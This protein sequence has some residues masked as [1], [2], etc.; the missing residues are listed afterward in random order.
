V[1]AGVD[2][3]AAS[4]LREQCFANKDLAA[5]EACRSYVEESRLKVSD[6][7]SL[8]R[9]LEKKNF[10]ENAV[11][12]YKHGLRYYPERKELLQQLQMAESFQKEATRQTTT[13]DTGARARRFATIQCTQL[14]GARA[15]EACQQALALDPDNATLYERLGDVLTGLGRGAEASQAYQNARRLGRVHA[16]ST[17]SVQATARPEQVVPSK[18]STETAPSDPVAVSA[19]AGKAPLSSSSRES[20]TLQVQLQM[21]DKLR[22]EGLISG[23]EYQGRRAKLLD[24]AFTA[25]PISIPEQPARID[26]DRTVLADVK[27]G[28]FYALVIGNDDYKNI[29]KLKSAIVDAKA[30]GTLLE[31]DYGF[32]VTSLFNASRYQIL[33]ALSGF[34]PKLSERDSFLI[35]YAGH[36]VLDEDI[37]RGYWLPIDAEAKNSANWLSTT[38]VIDEVHAIKALH[39][40]VVSDSC[41]SAALM[42]RGLVEFDRANDPS[43]SDRHALIRRLAKKRSRTILT[44]GGLEPVLDS[45]GGEHSVFAKAFLNTLHENQGI[46]EGTRLFQKLR[47]LVVYKADQTPE[48]APAEKSG[49]EGGDFIFV[50]QR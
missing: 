16:G 24:T 18:P 50:R 39:V 27:L 38:A 22:K 21:L 12:V 14:Q 28:N 20:N 7:I 42:R 1:A 43:N 40:L 47:E 23:E 26:D 3:F 34:R 45:G 11:V 25:Q 4:N 6:I 44:S 5:Q 41:F 13:P 31:K 17:G 8:G 10:F 32:R 2:V 29:P 15:L 37:Q 35:Y 36:G 30:V 33:S 48:Y 9:E 19:P 49:H 46:M